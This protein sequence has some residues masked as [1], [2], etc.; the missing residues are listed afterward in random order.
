[1][2]IQIINIFFYLGRFPLLEVEFMKSL[3]ILEFCF[4]MFFIIR[5]QMALHDIEVQPKS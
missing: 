3:K 5:L 1:M 2:L 4:W